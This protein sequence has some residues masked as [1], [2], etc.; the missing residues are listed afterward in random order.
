MSYACKG[1]HGPAGRDPERRGC[2]AGARP[3]SRGRLPTEVAGRGQK[4]ALRTG[5]HNTPPLPLGF[6]LHQICS[7][8][9]S[10][11]GGRTARTWS[12][13]VTAW[14]RPSQGPLPCGE[15]NQRAKTPP[16]S[17]LS[18][19]DSLCVRGAP[20]WRLQR[21]QGRMGCFL[22]KTPC[23]RLRTLKERTVTLSWKEL[24]F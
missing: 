12:E 6:Q 14:V 15:S 4:G 2:R 10:D 21:R 19:G 16:A 13:G 23:F 24:L 9:Q 8:Q 17:Q 3:G 5:A 11:P 20:P 18:G 7:L 1:L 22:L